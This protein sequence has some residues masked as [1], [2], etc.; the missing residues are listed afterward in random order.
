M[1]MPSSDEYRYCIRLGMTQAECARHL[2]V[3]RAAVSKA[4][5]KMFLQFGNGM[6]LSQGKQWE[7]I[8][9]R[10]PLDQMDVLDW[11]EVDGSPGKIACLASARLAPKRFRSVTRNGLQI[12]QRAA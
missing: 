12:V 9:Y 11:C 5:R 3:S 7:M 4:A 2:G 8:H 10:Y 6:A 1:T